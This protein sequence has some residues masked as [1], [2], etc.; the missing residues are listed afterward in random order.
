MDF[1]NSFFAVSFFATRSRVGVLVA[2]TAF[3]AGAA[4]TGAGLDAGVALGTI[5]GAAFGLFTS[6][7]LLCG[8]EGNTREAVAV[9]EKIAKAIKTRW[10]IEFIFGCFSSKII[11]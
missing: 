11:L 4:F 7:L 9:S 8:K 5:A 10:V 1:V 2:T 6:L 3:G